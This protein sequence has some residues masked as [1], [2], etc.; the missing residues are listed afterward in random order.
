MSQ[1]LIDEA[2]AKVD[3]AEAARLGYAGVIGYVSQDNTGKN[4]SQYDVDMIH[5]AGLSVGL[6]Y[7]Y[8]PQSAAGGFYAGTRDADIAIAYAKALGAPP[9]VCLYA[10][11]D[12]DV[13]NTQMINVAEYLRGYGT[14]VEN[15][16]YRHGMYAGYYPCIWA[17]QNGY[18]GLLWQT[19]AWS[20]GLWFDGV[21]VRQTA[22]GIIV[23]GANVDRDEAEVT[24][25]G[26]WS[27][28][29]GSTVTQPTDT[30]NQQQVYAALFTGGSSCGEM[31]PAEFRVPTDTEGNAILSKLNYVQAV[32]GRLNI[33]LLSVTQDQ[34][35]AIG[36]LNALLSQ[37]AAHLK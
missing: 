28:D 8:S 20:G 27:P 34:M 16:G 24:D 30:W 29:G 17:R 21:A 9:G 6:V 19:Y 12:W 7:E 15:A 11:I 5:A 22:N 35:D 31:V 33:P 26:Q 18:Q 1:L 36:R 4:L 14:R 37:V 32:I 2:W 23:G 13:S 3:P 25:W 10:A